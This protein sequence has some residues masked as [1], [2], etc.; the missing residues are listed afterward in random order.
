MHQNLQK[1][2]LSFQILSL[3]HLEICQQALVHEAVSFRSPPQSSLATR[4]GWLIPGWCKVAQTAT[5]RKFQNEFKGFYNLHPRKLKM[6]FMYVYEYIHVHPKWGRTRK[7]GK[8][9]I[10]NH[11]MFFWKCPRLSVYFCLLK[12]FLRR[13]VGPLVTTLRWIFVSFLRSKFSFFATQLCIKF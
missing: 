2:Y 10:G 4:K 12:V 8:Y 1:K 5:T 3:F 9:Y 6:V 13:E 7:S 11:L